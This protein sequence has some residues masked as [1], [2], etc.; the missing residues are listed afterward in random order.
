M[1]DRPDAPKPADAPEDELAELPDPGPDVID[2][3]IGIPTGP[4]PTPTDP[5]TPGAPLSP[6]PA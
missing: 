4:S 1:A 3:A 5:G 6:G 2:P